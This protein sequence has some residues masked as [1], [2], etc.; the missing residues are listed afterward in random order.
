MA[1]ELIR[2]RLLLWATAFAAVAAVGLP[3]WQPL[4][5]AVSAPIVGSAIGLALF[6]AL[7]GAPRLPPAPLRV[8]AARAAYLAA[9]AAFEEVLWRGL[10]LGLL[11]PRIGVAAALAATSIAFALSHRRTPGPLRALHVL[12]GLGFGAAFLCAGLVAA[13]VGHAVYNILIDL[14]VQAERGPRTRP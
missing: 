13:I 11:G 1:S 5:P 8:T 6:V 4:A 2:G 12:T 7:A 14:G 9:A 10:G 3:P